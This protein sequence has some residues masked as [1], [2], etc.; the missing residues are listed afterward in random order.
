MGKMARTDKFAFVFQGD[1]AV[2]VCI[3]KDPWISLVS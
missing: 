2:W 3:V 1:M